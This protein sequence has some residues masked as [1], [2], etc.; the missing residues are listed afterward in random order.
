MFGKIIE[1]ERIGQK[2]K[3]HFTERSGEITFISSKT[4]HVYSDFG[5]EHIPSKAVVNENIEKT[6]IE[7]TQQK[8][9]VRIRTS[10]L[11]VWVYDDFKIDI[12]DGNG[13]VL[14]K[15]YRGKRMPRITISKESAELM[16]KEGHKVALAKDK[17]EIEVVKEMS[18]TTAFYG[19]GDMTGFLNKKGYAYELWNTDN[20]MPHVD[21]FKTLYKSIP[22]MIA[23]QPDSVYGIFMDSTCHSYW[24][25]GQESSEYY[26][27]ATDGGNL[28]YYFYLGESIKE[29]LSAYTRMTG[30]VPIPQMWT[31]GYHQSRWGYESK[32]DIMEVANK[33]R[34]LEIPC[35][36]IHF[37][38]DYM[39][40]FK[41]FTFNKES[42]GEP[43]ILME[44]L[45][46]KGFKA[47]AILD[48]AVK[49]EEGY[50]IYEEGK[51]N[52]YF[53]TTPDGEIYTNV[54]WPGDAVYPD[55]GRI[56]VRQWWMQKEKKL[57]EYGFR[58]IWNDMNEPAGFDGEIPQN[59]VFG[60]E[61][62]KSTHAVM[63]NVY[64]HLMSK[65]AYEGLQEHDRKRPFVIT[66]ACYAGS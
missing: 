59:I 42:Y 55:F 47:V 57:V 17:Y 15:D 31:L 60:D 4:F 27:F 32:N 30:T 56:Q 61:D 35:D 50:D 10:D 13:N 36:A 2:I 16:K 46:E 37:D 18:H 43:E 3:I 39:E 5:V 62:T 53:V 33:M 44:Q 45:T 7:V 52:N 26:Y 8:S 23:K 34:Q 48:P 40:Q 28:N 14:C 66:R 20:P 51:K 9:A 63:H 22:F 58:G 25:F 54:V 41:V 21:S 64:G 6:K 29:I 19:L 24:D 65:A 38:I 49:V 11:I 12:Y 1:Y